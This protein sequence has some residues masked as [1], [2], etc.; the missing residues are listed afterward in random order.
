MAIFSTVMAMT[1]AQTAVITTGTTWA[2]LKGASIT[3][4]TPVSIFNDGSVRVYLTGSSATTGTSVSG[5]P[6]LSSGTFT[7]SLL[8]SDPIFALTSAGT[9]STIRVMAGRQRGGARVTT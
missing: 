4:P 3:D 2:S 8:Q 9:T 7:A 6:L 5:F 1:S